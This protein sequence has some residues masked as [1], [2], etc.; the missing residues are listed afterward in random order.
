M[1]P[2][3]IHLRVVVSSNEI[4]LHGEIKG[5]PVSE[6]NGEDDV[7]QA[8]KVQWQWWYNNYTM[9]VGYYTIMKIYK[10][11]VHKNKRGSLYFHDVRA[12]VGQY[13]RSQLLAGE[14]GPL[15]IV[16]L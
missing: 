16:T 13:S 11:P 15:D 2:G 6:P 4:N 1:R 12:A 5:I 10:T 7:V 8:W 14:A 9:V 3:N